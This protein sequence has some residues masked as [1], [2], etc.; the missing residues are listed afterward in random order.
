M[1]VRVGTCMREC[2]CVR[3]CVREKN[4]KKERKRERGEKVEE[5]CKRDV[6][7]KDRDCVHSRMSDV[8]VS[9]IRKMGCASRIT[10][11]RRER[12]GRE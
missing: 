11:E 2:A 3:A 9:T 6:R 8:R 12:N 5:R 1:R 10:F 7:E 4:R